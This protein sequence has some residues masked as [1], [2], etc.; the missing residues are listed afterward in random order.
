[1]SRQ[2]DRTHLDLLLVLTLETGKGLLIWK[3]SESGL[4]LGAHRL[5]FQERD[6]QME[7]KPAREGGSPCWWAAL[8]AKGHRGHAAVTGI[9]EPLW[10]SGGTS[11][12]EAMK[13]T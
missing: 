2:Q 7:G 8:L 9:K 5:R 4:K 10:V 11:S 3:R 1:M 13:Q 12:T 6:W